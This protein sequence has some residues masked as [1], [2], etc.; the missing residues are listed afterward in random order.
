MLTERSVE[1]P[2]LIASIGHPRRILDVGSAD[3]VYLG[4]L[5][6]ICRDI[7]LCDTR[8]FVSSIP[9]TMFIGPAHKLPVGWDGA[10]DLITCISVLD[11]VGLD[12]Y[13]NTDDGALLQETIDTMRRLLV[14]NGRLLLTVPF[15]RAQITTHPGGKQRVFDLA[16]L[17][18]LFDADKWQLIDFAVWRLAADGH[19]AESSATEAATATYL[20]WRAEAVVAME[21]VRL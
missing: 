4:M 14:T 16:T 7:T 20:E 12:A 9:A 10:F 2:W 11:H 6:E 17:L 1:L 8:D 5:Y 19:Y 15:G 13:G 3:A 21:I 18:N